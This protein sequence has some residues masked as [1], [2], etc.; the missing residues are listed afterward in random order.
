VVHSSLSPEKDHHMPTK[1]DFDAALAD[2]AA[3]KARL[4]DTTA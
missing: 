4:A 3:A 2:I 1:A